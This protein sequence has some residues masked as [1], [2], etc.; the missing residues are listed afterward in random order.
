MTKSKS[1]LHHTLA[2]LAL[3]AAT[4]VAFH[5]SA[6]AEQG[7]EAVISSGRWEKKSFAA[8]GSWSIV[9]RGGARYVTLSADFKTKNAPDLKI[10]LSPKSAGELN[11]RN[12]TDGSI[13]IAPLSSASGAQEYEI[14]AGVDLSAYQTIII[15]CEAF[16]KLWSV[17][18]L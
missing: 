11:G 8:D 18:P 5:A 13:L 1:I 16:S 10:F 4:P 17:A 15:H 2:A 6:A 12:A 7:D 9:D 3:I 14:P